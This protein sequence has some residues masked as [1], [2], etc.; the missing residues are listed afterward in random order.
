M[1]PP[2]LDDL[3]V[4]SNYH[5][6]EEG[7]NKKNNAL[8]GLKWIKDPS[9]WK[10]QLVTV[11]KQDVTCWSL[12]LSVFGIGK[13]SGITV[14]LRN[15]CS[16]L[17]KFNWQEIKSTDTSKPESSE[18]KV[19]NTVCHIA[20]RRILKRQ[21][22]LFYAVSE[23]VSSEFNHYWNPA[24]KG[25]FLFD[26]QCSHLLYAEQMALRFKDTKLPV[27]SNQGLSKEDVA[28]I[29]VGYAFERIPSNYRKVPD[30]YREPPPPYYSTG[31]LKKS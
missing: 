29:E 17:A 4:L 13:L 25:R 20:N 10:K 8:I 19:F 16:Y 31:P 21:L 15:I 6:I 30:Y 1:N 28:R 23:P 11:D 7:S 24:M 22:E 27:E 5:F 12:F 14:S 26:L 2:N 3:Q 18:Y 9:G